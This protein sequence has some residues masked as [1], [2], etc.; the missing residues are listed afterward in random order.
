METQ[1]AS[2]KKIAL[3]F[4][5]LLALLSIVLQVIAY[6]TDTHID[7]PWW[8]NVT[9]ILISVGVIV[10]GLKAFK[11]DNGGFMSLGEALKAGLAISL[12][13]GI[14]GAIFNY[15]FITVIEPDFVAQTMEYTREQMIAQNPNMTEE[16]MEM[17]L[18]ISEKMMTPWIMS[19]MAIIVT[20]F[21][22]FIISLIAGLIMKQNRPENY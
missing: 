16:Q 20:L 10:Y 2:V 12:I 7:R 8:L 19:A 4:G 13:A 14:I 17:G 21:F 1:T 9:G 6:V 22:G 11:N 18:S 15:I 3:N 5:L